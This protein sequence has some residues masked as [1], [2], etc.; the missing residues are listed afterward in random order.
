[1]AVSPAASAST[2]LIRAPRPEVADSLARELVRSK[3]WTER[4]DSTTFVV[5]APWADD[6][7]QL[8]V[9]LRFFVRAWQLRGDRGVI[10]VAQVA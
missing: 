3:C 2:V 4:I 5:T 10:E 9:E 6:C 8:L 7:E 1:M